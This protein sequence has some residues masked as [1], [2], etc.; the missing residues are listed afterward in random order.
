MKH[1]AGQDDELKAEAAGRSFLTTLVTLTFVMNLIARGVPETFA[2][3]LLP[4]QQGLG[5]SRSGI[6][7]TYSVYM[8]AY[9]FSGPL[10]GQLID[11]GGARV[12][13]EQTSR[14]SERTDA[15][16]RYVLRGLAPDLPLFIQVR[17][18]VVESASSAEISLAPDEVR[19]GVEGL[20]HTEFGG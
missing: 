3:F 15:S 19:R 2:V 5:A 11:R 18:E 10:A 20:G 17:G 9:G 16:G 13:Y 12:N 1:P 6:T 14:R 7:L 8:L 4:V